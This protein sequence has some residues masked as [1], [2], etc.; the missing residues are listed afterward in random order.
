M[1]LTRRKFVGCVGAAVAATLLPSPALDSYW[2]DCGLVQYFR[3]PEGHYA[4]SH[5]LLNGQR[6]RFTYQLSCWHRNLHR[7]RA[8]RSE[9]S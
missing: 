5:I 9:R 7:M 1:H 8:L 6:Q 3:E 2:C 4:A